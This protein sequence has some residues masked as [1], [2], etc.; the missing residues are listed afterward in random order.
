MTALERIYQFG[1]PSDSKLDTDFLVN[2]FHV[3]R[4]IAIDKHKGEPCDGGYQK[5][6]IDQQFEER[7]KGR[8]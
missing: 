2:A 5:P 8:L 4:E 7:M 3:M 6:I 1:I